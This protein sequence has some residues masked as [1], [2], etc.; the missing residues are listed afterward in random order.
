MHHHIN[1]FAMMINQT[2]LLKK[3]ISFCQST[4]E[5]LWVKNSLAEPLIFPFNP[6]FN[7]FINC[8]ADRKLYRD[9]LMQ[10]LKIVS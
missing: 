2:Y 6:T 8:H 1:A 3:N 9:F 5:V 7:I 10:S 4:V